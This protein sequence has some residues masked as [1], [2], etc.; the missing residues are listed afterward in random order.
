MPAS[1]DSAHVP[2]FPPA[3]YLVALAVG[4]LLQW[5]VPLSIG[6]SWRSG[7][8]WLGYALIAAGL[9]LMASS[10][11]LFFRAG[12]APNPTRP[13]TALVLRGAYRF[14]RNPMYVGLTLLTAGIGL[15][16]HTL[17]PVLTALAAAVVTQR[18]VIAREEQYLEQKFGAPYIEYTKRVRRWL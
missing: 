16:A 8:G 2:V 4:L 12:T 6:A 9:S 1:D 7:G 3:I 13:T 18:V 17:W 14:T 11:A 10:V 15:A 5:L